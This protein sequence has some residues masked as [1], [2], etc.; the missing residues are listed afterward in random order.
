MLYFN[1]AN[2]QYAEGRAM[3]RPYTHTLWNK[4]MGIQQVAQ[5]LQVSVSELK[6]A[7]HYG[8]LIRGVAPPPVQRIT[9]TGK[10]LFSGEAVKDVLVQ[11]NKSA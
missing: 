8:K 3:S 1:R 6:D 11:L 4:T 9:E 5:L 10:L 2:P 7:I